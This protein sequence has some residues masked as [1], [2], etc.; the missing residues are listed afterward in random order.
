MYEMK[1]STIRDALLVT[2]YGTAILS[3][4]DNCHAQNGHSPLVAWHEG[5]ETARAF[6]PLSPKPTTRTRLSAVRSLAARYLL[7]LSSSFRARYVFHSLFEIFAHVYTRRI[8]R[9]ENGFHALSLRW[10]GNAICLST[11]DRSVRDTLRLSLDQRCDLTA[12]LLIG[13]CEATLYSRSSALYRAKL[14]RSSSV[15]S[16][17]VKL[18]ENGSK[19]VI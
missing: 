12:A 5:L 14:I 2:R 3:A 13:S 16:S 8:T 7:G 6:A 1:E 17:K 11:D 10:R 9:A 19:F 18:D 4:A 15:K